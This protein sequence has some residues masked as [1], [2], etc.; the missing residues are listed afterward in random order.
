MNL[1]I[2]KKMQP[3]VVPCGGRQTSVRIS[4]AVQILYLTFEIREHI[5]RNGEFLLVLTLILHLSF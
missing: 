5:L 3:G 4:S 2:M 1:V